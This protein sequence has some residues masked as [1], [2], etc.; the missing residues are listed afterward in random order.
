MRNPESRGSALE[1]SRSW[2]QKRIP[3]SRRSD[4]ANRKMRATQRTPQWSVPGG[5]A[6]LV[7][8]HPV[9][10]ALIVAPGRPQPSGVWQDGSS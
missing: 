5:P 10:A 1:G 8:I 9:R 2:G 6:Q 3:V 7:R 4:G